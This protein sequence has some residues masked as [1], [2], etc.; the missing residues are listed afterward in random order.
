MSALQT[1]SSR[2]SIMMPQDTSKYNV[3]LIGIF[4][5]IAFL[6]IILI[7]FSKQN[8]YSQTNLSDTKH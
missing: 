1:N 5:C 7:I 6:L 4:V 3:L 2:F 8:C